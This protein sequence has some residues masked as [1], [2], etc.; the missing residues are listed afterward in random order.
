MLMANVIELAN[1]DA[2]TNKIIAGGN[3]VGYYYLWYTKAT[4]LFALRNDKTLTIPVLPSEM[5]WTFNL[6]THAW[7]YDLPSVSFSPPSNNTSLGALFYTPPQLR[8]GTCPRLDIDEIAACFEEQFGDFLHLIV[9]VGV[10]RHVKDLS[11]FA[12]HGYLTF[13]AIVDRNK[14]KILAYFPSTPSPK[15]SCWSFTTGVEASYSTSVFFDEVQFSLV[16]TFQSNPTSSTTP[17][18]LFIPPIPVEVVDNV[19]CI[20]YPLSDTLFFW[21]SDPDGQD[22]IDEEEWEAYGIPQLEIFTWIGSS[23]PWTC[24][25][26]IQDYLRKKSCAPD[27]RQYAR[28]HGYPELA[29]GDPRNHKITVLEEP[30]TPEEIHSFSGQSKHQGDPDDN[31]SV[32]LDYFSSEAPEPQCKMPIKSKHAQL[33]HRFL[34]TTKRAPKRV[35]SMI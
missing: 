2:Y 34:K 9:S 31:N 18:Y 17:A 13:G 15:W 3:W 16:G 14:P 32:P 6:R 33:L 22:V 10:T 25:M 1:G 26:T 23:W 24:Y 28:E 29:Y 12:R 8:Q 21:S 19:C 5:F 27:G 35:M 20:R 11:D 7:Q 4:S 30:D